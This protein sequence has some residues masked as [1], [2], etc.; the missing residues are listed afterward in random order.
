MHLLNSSWQ[1]SH[2]DIFLPSI[3]IFPSLMSCKRINKDIILLKINQLSSI[4]LLCYLFDD[5][6]YKICF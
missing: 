3:L 2:K 1:P 4:N 5:N 6:I